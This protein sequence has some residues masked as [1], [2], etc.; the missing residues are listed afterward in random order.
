[1]KKITTVKTTR[2]TYIIVLNE[3][4]GVYMAIN[5]KD[6]DENGKLT[7]EY[8]GITALSNKDKIPNY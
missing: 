5:E 1:M 2:S 3:K 4:H 6:I 7:K 8:N